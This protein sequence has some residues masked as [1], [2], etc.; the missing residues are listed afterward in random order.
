MSPTIGQMVLVPMNPDLNSGADEAM[1]FVSRVWSDATDDAPAS[2]SVRVF[3]DGNGIEWRTAL[4]LL[5]EKPT[6][7]ALTPQV[8]WVLPDTTSFGGA[9]EFNGEKSAP[10]TFSEG[11]AS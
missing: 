7:D 8:C 2:V 5:S 10:L 1:A 3:P 9:E 4:S 6:G 11:N